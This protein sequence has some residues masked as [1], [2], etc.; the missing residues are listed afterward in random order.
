MFPHYHGL[1]AVDTRTLYDGKPEH[2]HDAFYI[3][4]TQSKTPP[5]AAASHSH[6]SDTMEVIQQIP[7]AKLCELFE[8]TNTNYLNS[9]SRCGN[10]RCNRHESTNSETFDICSGCSNIKY[11]SAFCKDQHWAKHKQVC[12]PVFL[13]TKTHLSGGGPP[14]ISKS[15]AD[16]SDFEVVSNSDDTDSLPDLEEC[17]IYDNKEHAPGTIK[18]KKE[19]YRDLDDSYSFVDEKPQPI[20]STEKKKQINFANEHSNNVTMRVRKHACGSK[21]TMRCI[22]SA[23]DVQTTIP[24]PKG[25]SSM[26]YADEGNLH[27]N[28]D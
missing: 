8:V 25:K 13:P 18:E 21:C 22:G 6:T 28:V 3:D 16:P 15:V 24:E 5:N 26:M 9:Q 11:C 19:H 14:L 20:E 4:L 17:S 7:L 10:D 12:V 23:A 2:G 27:E 1:F